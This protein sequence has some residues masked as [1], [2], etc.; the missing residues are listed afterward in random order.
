MQIIVKGDVDGN[1]SF[2]DDLTK[3][4]KYEIATLKQNLPDITKNLRKKINEI[5]NNLRPKVLKYCK[6]LLVTTLVTLEA[7]L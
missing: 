5:I 1:K 7:R 6:S 3:V 4:L 2:L